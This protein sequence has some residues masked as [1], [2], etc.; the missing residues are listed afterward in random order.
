M[1]EAALG[2]ERVQLLLVLFAFLAAILTIA[3][4]AIVALR[5]FYGARHETPKYPMRRR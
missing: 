2:A 5:P 1:L 4:A 3:V